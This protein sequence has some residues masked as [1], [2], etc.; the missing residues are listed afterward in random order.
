[1]NWKITYSPETRIV[2]IETEGETRIEGINA[3][4]RDVM[5]SGL[6]YD[7]TRFLVDHRKA[8]FKVQFMDFYNRPQ[9]LNTIGF[10][11]NSKIAQV[12]PESE[13]ENFRFFET[14]SVNAGYVI[15]V[16]KTIETAT[17]WLTEN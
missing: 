3:M 17:E 6:K 2:C 1:M 4:V 16:F 7:S 12:C 11:R 13:Y 9:F 15:R 14:V 5:E 8:T 10:P